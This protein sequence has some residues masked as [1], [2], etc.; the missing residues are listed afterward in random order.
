MVFLAT[1]NSIISSSCT[2]PIKPPSKDSGVMWP[3]TKP[4]VPPLNLPSVIRA[5]LLPK[6]AP[7]K[8]P[9][10]F[11]ISGMPGAPLGPTCLITTTSP[12]FIRPELMPAI[13]SNSPSNTRA[14][15]V[16]CSPSLPVIF[17]TLPP[18]ARLPYNI[19]KCPVAFMGLSKGRMIFC[20]SKSRSG[21][22]ARFSASVLP[23]TV[24]QSP[25][26]KPFCSRYFITA[27]IP[28][29]SCRSCIKYLPLGLKSASTG[30][31]SLIV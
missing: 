18:S 7:I 5:T 15:P 12:A 22:S 8:A 25:C 28:P 2:R 19:C 9:V 3:T 24:R 21:I 11:N 10:G 4:C 17:A 27:G 16:N 1:L 29:C 20:L 31:L 14:G 23:V 26:S 30:I 13:S 6:P